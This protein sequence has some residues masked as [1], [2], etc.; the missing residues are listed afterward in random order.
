MRD[1]ISPAP[2]GAGRH[3]NR[4]A[5]MI[6]ILGAIAA[7]LGAAPPGPAHTSETASTVAL[8][9]FE[10]PEFTLANGTDAR[11]S[12]SGKVS[13]RKASCR[14]GRTV[15]LFRS[16]EDPVLVGKDTTNAAGDWAVFKEDPRD[17]TYFAKLT[18]RRTGSGNHQHGC[19]GDKSPGLEAD[20]TKGP[21]DADDDGFYTGPGGD[22]DDTDAARNPDAAE[23]AGDGKDTDC[24][25]VGDSDESDHDDDGWNGEQDCDDTDPSSRAGASEILDGKDNDCDGLADED[26]YEAR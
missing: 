26:F 16:P 17:G 21:T 14:D 7:P 9:A 4:R 12:F 23:D 2:Q 6:G 20:D 18:K 8:S 19:A 5:V 15:K 1:W 11:D 25:G 13:S 22:C 10:D 3:M 24:D